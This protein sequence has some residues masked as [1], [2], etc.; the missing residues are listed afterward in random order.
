MTTDQ[1]PVESLLARSTVSRSWWV[2]PPLVALFWVLRGA[3]GAAASLLGIGI[4]IANFLL[5]GAIL[6]L[7][8]RISIGMYH[9]AAFISFLLRLGLLTGT[10]L[11]V[12]RLVEVDRISFGI[13]AVVGYLVL[14]TLEAL[15][16]ARGRE[17]KPTWVK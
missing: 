3:S 5:S 11:V 6:S 17:R 2:A 7:G 1:V 16:V 12:V 9:A 4:V 8:M 15:A 13:S 10:M 14:L